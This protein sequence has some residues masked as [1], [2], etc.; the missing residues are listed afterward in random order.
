[1]LA[2][3]ARVFKTRS[4]QSTRANPYIAIHTSSFALIGRQEWTLIIL[5]R[6]AGKALRMSCLWQ[7]VRQGVGL[8]GFAPISTANTLLPQLT[9]PPAT[10]SSDTPLNMKQEL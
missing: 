5:T 3:P 7:E 1:M 10:L 4:P 8:T 6:Y 9:Q 2:L